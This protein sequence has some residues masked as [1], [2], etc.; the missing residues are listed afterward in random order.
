MDECLPLYDAEGGLAADLA[1]WATARGYEG[2]IGIDAYVHRTAEG[3]LVLRPI[4]EVNP[5]HTMGLVA[6]ELKRR[7]APGRDLAFSIVK[8]ADLAKEDDEGE[9]DENG[10]LAKGSVVLTWC[11]DGARFAAVA[12][13]L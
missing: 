5:R 12:R 11:D 9:I 4:C 6:L 2:P 7:I 10:K 8:T 3:R 1:A 13:V